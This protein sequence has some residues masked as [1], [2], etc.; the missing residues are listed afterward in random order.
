MG[1]VLRCSDKKATFINGETFVKEGE[2][3]VKL[4][5][6]SDENMSNLKNSYQEE[7]QTAHKIEY[8]KVDFSMNWGDYQKPIF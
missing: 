4:S 5:E 1:Y 8:G 6:M 3:W 2:T 7:N